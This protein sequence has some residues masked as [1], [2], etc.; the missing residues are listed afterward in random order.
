[1]RDRIGGIRSPAGATQVSDGAGWPLSVLM[2]A[3]KARYALAARRAAVSQ[4]RVC[5]LTHP[6]ATATPSS[7]Q[8]NGVAE[9]RHPNASCGPSGR[10]SGAMPVSQGFASLNPG[11]Y[12]NRPFRPV[13]TIGELCICRWCQT[14]END[15]GTATWA[16]R[17]SI[18][19]VACGLARCLAVILGHSRR[20]GHCLK[21]GA[22]ICCH[23]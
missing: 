20:H 18:C 12:S 21:A 16:S 23:R 10:T 2:P 17:P 11:L 9:F 15:A 6:G 22:R 19:R 1:V 14:R 8:P 13:R 7:S 4:P 3:P 5:V